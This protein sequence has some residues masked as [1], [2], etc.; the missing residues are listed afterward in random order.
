M[1]RRGNPGETSSFPTE[2][3]TQDPETVRYLA[4]PVL[5]VEVVDFGAVVARIDLAAMVPDE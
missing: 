5:R 1:R 4:T 3:S 2:R